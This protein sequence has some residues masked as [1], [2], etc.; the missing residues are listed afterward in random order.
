MPDSVASASSRTSQGSANT[1]SARWQ[2]KARPTSGDR[3]SAAAGVGSR[4]LDRR[5]RRPSPGG[6]LR[7][8]SHQRHDDEIE[9]AR[10]DRVAVRG[11]VRNADAECAAPRL[12][13]QADR[14]ASGDG[15]GS[16]TTGTKMRTPRR[17][18][19]AMSAAGSVSPIEGQIER[20][21]AARLECRQ[22]GDR[23]GGRAGAPGVIRRRQ[24]APLRRAVPCAASLSSNG[25]EHEMEMAPPAYAVL[26]RCSR[27]EQ[28][29]GLT[30]ALKAFRSRRTCTMLPASNGPWGLQ[31]RVRR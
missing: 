3:A 12:A 15:A 6:A 8:D 30:A 4:A 23:S 26:D 17:R 27:P 1:E 10:R 9:P 31:I 11:A 16:T 24:R 19:A 25:A 14:I 21:A 7:I 18:A 20:D 2:S 22:P 5:I 28:Q 29:V 13:G